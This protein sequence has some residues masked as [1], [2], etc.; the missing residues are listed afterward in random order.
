LTTAKA[1]ARTTDLLNKQ[2]SEVCVAVEK[3]I[4]AVGINDSVV[5]AG[6]DSGCLAAVDERPY[7][8]DDDAEPV[9]TGSVSLGKCLVSVN[10]RTARGDQQR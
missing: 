3:V 10:R 8:E 9:V 4:K 1:H 7:T 5:G 6:C 2:V